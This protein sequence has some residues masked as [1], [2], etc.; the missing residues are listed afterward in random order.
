MLQSHIKSLGLLLLLFLTS[1]QTEL[2]Q[3]V[4]TAR[5][6]CQYSRYLK[7]WPTPNGGYRVAITNPDQ[8]KEVQ[9]FQIDQPI[10]RIAV[11]SAT[12][13]GMLAALKEHQK[14]CAIPDL[15]YLY[16]SKLIKMVGEKQVLDLRIGSSEISAVK[17]LKSKPDVAMYSGFGFENQ[18]MSRLKAAGILTI[19]NYEWREQ[20]PLARAEWVLL[21]GVLTGKF[22]EAKALHLQIVKRYEHLK[23]LARKQN[24]SNQLPIAISGNL[25]GDQWIAPAGESYEATLLNDA[26][27]AYVFGSERGSGSCFKSIATVLQKAPMINI[28]LNPGLP[29]KSEILTSNP[30]AR[31]YPFFN[32]PIFCYTAYNTNK[33]WEQS[34]IHPDWLLS[35]YIRIAQ[36]KQDQLHFF[37]KLK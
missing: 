35:D 16:D 5:N 13:V 7:I 27:I 1:C 31:F 29:S 15:K 36:K 6:A 24:K 3:T 28:W 19:A 37:A 26:G 34:V 18:R 9:H 2:Q 22:N 10:D 21:F 25:Y 14:I 30:K 11:L 4:I 32:K 17:I 23:W 8:P 20:T 33:C 12:H